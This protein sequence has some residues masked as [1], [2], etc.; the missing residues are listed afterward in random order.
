M[1]HHYTRYKGVYLGRVT[2]C[3][4]KDVHKYI[5]YLG[6]SAKSELGQ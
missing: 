4:C 3:I 6:A 5:T 1:K 2:I